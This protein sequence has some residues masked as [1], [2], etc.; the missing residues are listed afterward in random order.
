MGVVCVSE[1]WCNLEMG[2]WTGVMGVFLVMGVFW[3]L[4][5]VKSELAC[6]Q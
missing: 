6:C 1:S 2:D 4:N 3:V 5:N